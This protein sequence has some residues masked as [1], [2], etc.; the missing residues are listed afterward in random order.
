MN[1]LIHV[2]IVGAPGSG[3]SLFCER[4]SRYVE[5]HKAGGEFVFS[6]Y[7]N[8]E[9]L[10]QQYCD[11]V[12]QMVD[13]T[14]LEESL[15][16]TPQLI[17]MHKKLILALT[18]FGQLEVSGH[19][20]DYRRMA[21]LMGVQ[22]VVVDSQKDVG[23]DE[24]LR[25]I[26]VA[27]SGSKGSGR[28]VHVDYGSDVEDA[29]SEISKELRKSQ[30]YLGGMSKRYLSIRLLEMPEATLEMLRSLPNY[31]S[32]VFLTEKNRRALNRE[33]KA[34]PDDIIHLA[35]HGFISGALKATL[36]HVDDDK[37]EHTLQHK[38]DAVLTH[39]F[40]G[41]VILVAV[42][43]GVFQ[44]TFTLGAYP[45]DWI[46]MGI[47]GL[48]EFL[49]LSMSEG[50]LASLSIEDWLASLLIDGIVQG[51]GAV[52]A[53]LP[54]IVILFFFISV[55]EDTGYMARVAFL[56]DKLMHKVGLHGK[57]FVPM[58]M[59]FGCNV[60]AI[61]AARSISNSKDRALTM[62]MIP[63]M[64]CSARLPVYMLF[65]G[66]F[67]ESRQSLVMISL[68]LVGILISILFALLLK[69]TSYFKSVKE[70]YVSELPQFRK[71][72]LKNTGSH[73][74]ERCAD[75]LKKIATVILWASIII[76]ALYYFPRNEALTKPY[77]DQIA[78][79]EHSLMVSEMS[80]AESERVQH[81]ID[82]ISFVMDAV[83][84][85][86]SALASI[87][88]WMEPVMRPLGFDWRLN[89]CILTG[90]PAK[91]AIVSTMGIL[92][93]QSDESAL[94]TSLKQSSD[95]TPV[96]AY[97]FLLFVLLYF[98]CIATIATLWREIGWKW[99]V[100]TV[101]NSMLLAWVVSFGF[102]Q[103]FSLL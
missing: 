35:R 46:Q 71:P 26:T 4:I 81:E 33:L 57:S 88:R 17:D 7:T 59:G 79:L 45:Q 52:L 102:F 72:T 42:L 16:V 92:Y 94:A 47:D 99:A 73:I 76:W 80:L 20:L 8:P 36:K 67:F 61:M 51:V 78:S 91:E 48:C 18:G 50:W 68:Y 2:A 30:Q 23:F 58:L 3:K 85:E 24:M 97:S 96:K 27:Y 34:S 37:S 65:V 90:L 19:E 55:M 32:V 1:G 22:V 5:S 44:S 41:F 49:R 38:I 25:E 15:V 12:V 60:P 103:I 82:S 100:F 43:F 98:P 93:H 64:S 101:V 69:R 14:D 74:W 77:Q 31:M 13:C 70:D 84:K 53:F 21:D 9:D 87:G 28:H 40:F 10:M 75:Y 39:K 63:F 62:L 89:V 56:M 6:V 66:A 11:V 95:F 86:H 54:N 29:V 83:Q